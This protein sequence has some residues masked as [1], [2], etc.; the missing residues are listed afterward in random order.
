MSGEIY[1]SVQSSE[2]LDRGAVTCGSNQLLDPGFGSASNDGQFSL[3]TL[4]H[5]ARP[6]FATHPPSNPKVV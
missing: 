2:N 5:L 6:N 4:P 1:G 3:S